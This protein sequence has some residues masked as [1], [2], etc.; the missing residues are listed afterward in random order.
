MSDTRERGRNWGDTDG[1]AQCDDPYLHIMARLSAR[2]VEQYAPRPDITAS[3]LGVAV[4][5]LGATVAEI[6]RD[7]LEFSSSL[8]RHS[9]ESEEILRERL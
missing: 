2:M 4:D 9:R 5:Q 7:D 6:F 3:I 1:F 8:W